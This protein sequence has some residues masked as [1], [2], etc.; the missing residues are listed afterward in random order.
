ML[1]CYIVTGPSLA[2]VRQLCSHCWQ[3]VGI[4]GA[5]KLCCNLIYKNRQNNILH[6]TWNQRPN[7]LTIQF[8]HLIMVFSRS[9]ESCFVS[10]F[11]PCFHL[12]RSTCHFRDK[13]FDR[14][15]N[16]LR[17]DSWV[18]I[19]SLCLC[20]VLRSLA[21]QRIYKTNL[22]GVRLHMPTYIIVYLTLDEESF[23]DCERANPEDG[24]ETLE[25]V[26][27]FD[28]SVS[29]RKTHTCTWETKALSQLVKCI[30]TITISE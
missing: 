18:W 8:T 10:S 1:K 9:S 5:S 20:F 30:V 23:C 6:N 7:K 17:I 28:F 2:A 4:G 3:A 25:G 13:V 11:L 14:L 19:C 29:Q 26:Q 27:C 22:Y 12:L 16:L 21:T 24:I 15:P